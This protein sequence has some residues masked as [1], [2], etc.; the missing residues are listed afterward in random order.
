[1][2][3]KSLHVCVFISFEKLPR[4]GN[5]IF[6]K[7]EIWSIDLSCFPSR[8]PFIT[9]SI[10]HELFLRG[11]VRSIFCV[12]EMAKVVGRGREQGS[13]RVWKGNGLG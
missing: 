5:C 13:R 4:E 7:E 9:L 8:F 3:I 12:L 10:C 2:Q 6:V 11:E 1:M